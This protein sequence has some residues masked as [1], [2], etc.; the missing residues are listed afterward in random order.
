MLSFKCFINL[1]CMIAWVCAQQYKHWILLIFFK[2]KH[3]QDTLCN[4]NL[5]ELWKT[6]SNCCILCRARSLW[7]FIAI[8]MHGITVYIGLSGVFD[9]SL[10][11]ASYFWSLQLKLSTCQ[12]CNILFLPTGSPRREIC[13]WYW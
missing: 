8:R 5:P 9:W 12:A 10:L 7:P 6:W 11:V 4:T 1:A 2:K 13:G 3:E